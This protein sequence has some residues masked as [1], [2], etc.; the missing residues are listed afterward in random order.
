VPAG[1]IRQN[2]LGT[3]CAGTARSNQSGH[4]GGTDRKKQTGHSSQTARNNNDKTGRSNKRGDHSNE[5]AYR[6]NEAGGAP[7]VRSPDAGSVRG[8]I[9]PEAP[10]GAPD[11][12]L[13]S[14]PPCR[15]RLEKCARRFAPVVMGPATRDACGLFK[16]AGSSLLRRFWPMDL[17]LPRLRFGA[18]SWNVGCCCFDATSRKIQNVD[19]GGRVDDWQQRLSR[20]VAGAPP[21]LLH[22]RAKLREKCTRACSIAVDF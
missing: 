3:C 5:T 13:K 21:D 4:T 17:G 2:A 15:R 6:S 7:A 1:S 10:A 11:D 18:F 20:A 8:Q 12:Q 19:V 9:D 22:W 16:Y 14:E